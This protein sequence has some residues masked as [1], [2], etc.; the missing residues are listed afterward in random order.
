VGLRGGIRH[1][2]L[3][4]SSI[5]LGNDRCVNVLLRKAVGGDDPSDRIALSDAHTEHG[6]EDPVLVKFFQ[7]GDF[8]VLLS[9]HLDSALR[10]GFQKLVSSEETDLAKRK[11]QNQQVEA[12]P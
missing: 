1:T 4:R 8:Q 10:S 5:Q 12:G 7:T 6:D 9:P 2:T 11:W 3:L